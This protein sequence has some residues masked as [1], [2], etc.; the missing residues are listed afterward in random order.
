MVIIHPFSEFVKGK[1]QENSQSSVKNVRIREMF[2]VKQG[3]VCLREGSFSAKSH[4]HPPRKANFLGLSFVLWI[5]IFFCSRSCEAGRRPSPPGH[6]ACISYRLFFHCCLNCQ[7]NAKKRLLPK[8]TSI[9]FSRWVREEAFDSKAVLPQKIK[10][11]R[12]PC[13]GSGHRAMFPS[14][15]DP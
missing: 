6:F 11:P 13:L 10:P 2:H 1:F 12:S 3:R 4:P 5:K 15:A 9:W 14:R 7:V 8:S